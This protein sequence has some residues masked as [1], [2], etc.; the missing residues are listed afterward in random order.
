MEK[1]SGSTAIEFP[2]IG[3]ELEIAIKKQTKKKKK[4][5]NK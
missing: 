4:K 1:A 2:K 5:K 3:K